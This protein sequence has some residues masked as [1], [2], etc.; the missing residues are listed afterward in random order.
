[1]HDAMYELVVLQNDNNKEKTKSLLKKKNRS[2]YITCLDHTVGIQQV[3]PLDFVL[4]VYFLHFK[5]CLSEKN[6]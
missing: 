5:V 1:M 4:P 6:N 2:S 3:L